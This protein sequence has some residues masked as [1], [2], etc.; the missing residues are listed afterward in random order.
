MRFLVDVSPGIY[1]YFRSLERLRTTYKISLRAWKKWSFV[2]F[3]G[4]LLPFTKYTSSNTFAAD[5][6][7]NSSDMTGFSGICRLLNVWGPQ[8]TQVNRMICIKFFKHL[9]S[10]LVSILHMPSKTAPDTL[11]LICSKK[12]HLAFFKNGQCSGIQCW[13]N[14][15][16]S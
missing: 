11:Y 12:G 2:A 7:R 1:C 8:S 4:F 9:C 6:S 3:R 14:F 15:D 5:L 10:T 16:K 13:V